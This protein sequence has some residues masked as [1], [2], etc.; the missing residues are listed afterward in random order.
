MTKH[1]I[2]LSTGV[3]L[4]VWSEGDPAAPPI[5]FLHG[6]P[7]SQRTWRHQMAE[8]ARDHYC[9]APDQRGYG[10]S[11]KPPLVSDY[12]ADKLTA[13][14]FALADALGVDQF[15]IAGHD[16]GGAIAWS[17]ALNGQPGA[18]DP[19]WS[20]RV[21]RAILANA[22]HPYIFQRLLITDPVQ[23]AASQYIRAFR[24]TANDA[25]IL[26]GGFAD[27]LG[28]T[29]NW[30]RDDVMEPAE[31]AA[32]L[33]S[34]ADGQTA[35]AMLNW[36]RA[37]PLHVPAM[38]EAAELPAMLQMGFPPLG[39]PALVIWAMEDSALPPGNLD[40]L[41]QLVPQ[42]RIVPVHGCGHFV[43]WEAPDAVNAAMRAWLAETAV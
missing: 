1:R 36:Y 20:G 14:I 29:I 28:R 4:D 30:G 26:G 41:D 43:P 6:F 13:D 18:P 27:F 31:R 37:T 12:S 5:I 32:L 8:F 39:I 24:D 38:D 19:A 35:I 17:V 23:R 9:I 22:P 3:E 33:A 42:G 25:E 34:W 16:W 7:E 15:T 11:S 21:P 40:G 2:S 10:V